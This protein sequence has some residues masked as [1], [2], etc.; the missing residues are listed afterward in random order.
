MKYI[1]PA[2]LALA[3]IILG[4]VGYLR[5][6]STAAVPYAAS[7]EQEVAITPGEPVA[8]ST[9]PA[10]TPDSYTLADVAKHATKSSCWTAI[11][12]SVYDLTSFIPMHPGGDRILAVCGIDG[13]SLFEAQHGD[14]PRAQAEL[15]TLKIGTLA[16]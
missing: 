10:S 1:Y 9:P 5:Y 2:A 15:A 13:T 4:T 7:N 12:G 16:P 6:G 8:S 11:G 14:T 3:F